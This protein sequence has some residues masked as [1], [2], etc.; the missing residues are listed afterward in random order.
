[1]LRDYTMERNSPPGL[2]EQFL[3]GNHLTMQR[4][5][6]SEEIDPL[7]S[8]HGR[9]RWSENEDNLQRENSH[10]LDGESLLLDRDSLSEEDDQPMKPI[11]RDRQSL[12]ANGDTVGFEFMGRHHPVRSRYE[13]ERVMAQDYDPPYEGDSLSIENSSPR[14]SNERACDPV[15]G[16]DRLSVDRAHT[17]KDFEK[18]ITELKKENFNLKLRI[19]FLEEQ[20]QRHCDNSSEELHRMNIELKVEVESLKH[21]YQEKQNLLIRASKAMESLAGEHNVTIQQLKNDHLKQL[22]EL[23]EA[24][25]Q[26]LQLLEELKHEKGE[27]EKVC[28]LLDQERMQRFNAEERLLAVKEQ[29]NKSMGI[30]EE[31]DWIIQCLNETLR[32]K[33]ALITQLEK[34]IHTMMPSDTSNGNATKTVS[35]LPESDLQEG[36]SQSPALTCRDCL[37]TKSSEEKEENANE[38]QKKVKEMGNVINELQQK[39][40]ASKAGLANEEKNAVKRDKA[41]QGLTLALK[42]K[43]KRK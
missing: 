21:E 37:A 18:Q 40:E 36:R 41:I 33:D 3:R 25:R 12:P 15:K 35:L 42:K 4:D 16:Y 7:R 28:V 30:L 13:R 32:S 23:G 10:T 14:G 1:M 43:N 5:S 22:R 6:W 20:V 29:Y 19:Y 27:L 38:W 8:N 11:E 9:D 39:M 17:M 24:S 2:E 31:R 26:K 34:Q